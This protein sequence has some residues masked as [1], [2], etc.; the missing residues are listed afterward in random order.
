MVVVDKKVVRFTEVNN[1]THIYMN[2]TNVMMISMKLKLSYTSNKERPVFLNTNTATF[3]CP[4]HLNRT[5]QINIT[6]KKQQCS[7]LN[8]LRM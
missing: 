2:L 7:M 1:Y 5:L 4:T 8:S 6:Q 3:Q